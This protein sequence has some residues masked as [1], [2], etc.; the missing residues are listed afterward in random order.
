MLAAILKQQTLKWLLLV[1]ATPIAFANDNNNYNPTR[2]NPV[3]SVA[4]HAQPV[5]SFAVERA[6]IG[7]VNSAFLTQALTY[8]V[9]PRLAVGTSPI[10]YFSAQHR[11]NYIAKY[12]FWQSHSI[13]WSASFA[14][15]RYRTEVSQDSTIESADLIMRSAQL[16]FNYYPQQSSW[17]IAGFTN[18]MCGYIDSANPLTYIY[19]I[20]CQQEYGMD[21]QSPLDK[22]SSVTVGVANL[23]QSGYSPWEDLSPGV[24]AAY[25]LFRPNNFFSRPSFGVYQSVRGQTLFLLSTTINEKN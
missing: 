11:Y 7:N 8:T 20:R 12:N 9:I 18:T 25:A 23:R 3:T 6:P 5:G 22:N 19:S 17:V 10:F 21:V 2:F 4:A 15:S 16:A 24:G 14:E 13:D 1:I